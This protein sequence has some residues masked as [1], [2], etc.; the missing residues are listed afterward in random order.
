MEK[1]ILG[2]DPGDKHGG[3]AVLGTGS[4]NVKLFNMPPTFADIY[5]LL[6]T[7]RDQCA[8]ELVC[9]LED[10]GKGIPGQSSSVTANFG[11]HNGHLEMALYALEIPTVKVTPAKWMKYYSNQVGTKSGLT[12][13]EWKNKLKGLAQTLYPSEKITLSTA[14]AILI[15]NY[16]KHNKI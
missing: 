12:V 4:N 7:I 3:I 10:V 2:I 1:I 16:G 5:Q 13:T 15:A 14:D 9:Y 8:G 6:K 11:R